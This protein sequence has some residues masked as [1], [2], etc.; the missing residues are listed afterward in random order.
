[1]IIR[2]T[3]SLLIAFALS[4]CSQPFGHSK[5]GNYFGGQGMS[6]APSSFVPKALQRESPLFSMRFQHVD[7]H[8]A[9]H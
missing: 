3:A 1:M 8:N 5:N 2:V 7:A 6:S 4:N 9:N